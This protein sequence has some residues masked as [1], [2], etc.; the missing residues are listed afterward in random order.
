[1]HRTFMILIKLAAV[2]VVVAGL[3]ALTESR[4]YGHSSQSQPAG[5]SVESM[6]GGPYRGSGG[7]SARFVREHGGYDPGMRPKG[8]VRAG[9]DEALGSTLISASAAHATQSCSFISPQR[10]G[11]VSEMASCGKRGVRGN[12]AQFVGAITRPAGNRPFLSQL[13]H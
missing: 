8:D 5:G 11:G 12:R 7:P 1:M 10:T 4:S 6:H 13:A 2:G 9:Q 3:V